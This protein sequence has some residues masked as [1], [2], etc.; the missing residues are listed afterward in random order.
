MTFP[1]RIKQWTWIYFRPEAVN[2]NLLKRKSRN[3]TRELIPYQ[4]IS[5]AKTEMKMRWHKA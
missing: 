2:Y 1:T 3:T 4:S 5:I